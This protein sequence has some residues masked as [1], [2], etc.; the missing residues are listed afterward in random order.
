MEDIET[1]VIRLEDKVNH[2]EKVPTLTS[3]VLNST[4]IARG[5]GYICT[6]CVGRKYKSGQ[7]LFCVY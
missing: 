4:P 1:R 2:I 7:W 5:T 6:R 3:G